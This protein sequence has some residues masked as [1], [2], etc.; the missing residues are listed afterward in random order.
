MGIFKY[1]G[2]EHI[3]MNSSSVGKCRN[4]GKK[5]KCKDNKVGGISTGAWI[6]AIILFVLGP[7][8]TFVQVPLGILQNPDA[9]GIFFFYR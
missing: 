8:V 9:F 6:G 3:I 7:V 5:E 4:V 2:I 1:D